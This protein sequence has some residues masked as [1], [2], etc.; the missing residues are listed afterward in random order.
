MILRSNQAQL[1]SLRHVLPAEL[2]GNHPIF[3]ANEWVAN[4]K[5]NRITVKPTYVGSMCMVARRGAAAAE[6]L[7]W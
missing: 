4:S 5:L 2:L 6:F 7:E 1:M 3:T